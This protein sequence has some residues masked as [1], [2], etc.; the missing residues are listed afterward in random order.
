MKLVENFEKALWVTAAQAT[1]KLKSLSFRGTRCAEESL[2]LL[3]LEPRE[4]S[5]FIRNDKIAYFFRSLFSRSRKSIVFR[6]L[7]PLTCSNRDCEPKA[8]ED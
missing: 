3:S 4:I 5:H 8:V 1:E 7:S 2:F 6:R